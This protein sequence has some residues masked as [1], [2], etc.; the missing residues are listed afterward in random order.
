MRERISRQP[1]TRGERIH[2]PQYYDFL[3][4]HP[5]LESTKLILR[6]YE[7]LEARNIPF[8]YSYPLGDSL[9]TPGLRERITAHFFIPESN[10]VIIVQ[11]G[12][13]FDNANRLQ[14]T[15]LTIALL[16]YAGFNVLWWGEPEIQATGID[17]MIDS[18][19]VFKQLNQYGRPLAPDDYEPIP[20]KRFYR[21]PPHP[22]RT[23][24]GA[25]R[26]TRRYPKR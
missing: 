16:E 1:S 18:E 3:T 22:K 15:A 11:G 20:Y 14:D 6:V 23:E 10:T 7:A 9:A 8:R 4:Q 21:R 25:R 5:E 13:W 17:A 2:N 26:R 24:V 19:P 12:Y